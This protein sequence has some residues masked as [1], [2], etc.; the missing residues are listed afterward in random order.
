M[1][2]LTA[3]ILQRMLRSAIAR[4]PSSGEVDEFRYVWE[5]L[6]RNRMFLWV[7]RRQL[8]DKDDYCIRTECLNR[9]VS[10]Q[11]HLFAFVTIIAPDHF[12]EAVARDAPLLVVQIH[13]GPPSLTK[14]LADRNRSF[15]RIVRHAPRHVRRLQTMR[16]NTSQMQFIESDV[17]SLAKLRAAAQAGHVIGCAIDYRDKNGKFAFINP[18]IFGFAKQADVPVVFL[19]ADVDEAGTVHI[20][21]SEPQAVSDETATAEA[22]RDFYN[23]LPGRKLDLAVK[24][25]YA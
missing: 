10:L 23:A 15:S 19:R 2:R 18:A 3:I 5:R 14:L 7:L 16:V 12:L 22:F 9:I 1:R 24:R 17:R 25:Y 8:A 20:A 4:Y 11:P 6:S 13:E 21:A